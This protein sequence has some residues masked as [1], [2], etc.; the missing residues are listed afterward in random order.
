[1]AP[2]LFA[3]RIDNNGLALRFGLARLIWLE[4]DRSLALVWFWLRLL[5]I[6]GVDFFHAKRTHRLDF[7]PRLNTFHMKLIVVAFQSEFVE[8]LHCVE[9]HVFH[10][11]LNLLATLATT[12][13]LLLFL[14]TIPVIVF[15]TAAFFIVGE[16]PVEMFFFE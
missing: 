13:I 10:R 6:F 12:L 15:R 9:F 2:R 4:L 8:F 1:M 3:I 7:V 11:L 14:I 5:Q 16:L